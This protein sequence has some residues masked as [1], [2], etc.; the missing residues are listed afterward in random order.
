MPRRGERPQSAIL[1]KYPNERQSWDEVQRNLCSR[2]VQNTNEVLRITIGLLDGLTGICNLIQRCRPRGQGEEQLRFRKKIASEAAPQMQ[3][4]PGGQ[5][6]GAP[7]AHQAREILRSRVDATQ[8]MPRGEKSLAGN[9]LPRSQEHG[10]RA[11]RDTTGVTVTAL[12]LCVWLW[13]GFVAQDRV[14]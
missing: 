14:D 11:L 5:R 12:S 9:R 7:V 10:L 4:G 8:L 1:K 13:A 3:Q 2:K 6:L